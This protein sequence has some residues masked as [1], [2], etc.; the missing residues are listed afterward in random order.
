MM[1]LGR[2]SVVSDHAHWLAC[3][4]LMPSEARVVRPL[5]RFLYCYRADA[6]PAPL[7]ELCTAVNLANRF[8]M[9]EA[10]DAGML[11]LQ[12]KCR[13]READ[14]MELLEHLDEDVTESAVELGQLA[15]GKLLSTYNPLERLA[16]RILDDL[17]MPKL[18]HQL[19][20]TAATLPATAILTL[21]SN[22]ELRSSSEDAVWGVARWWVSQHYQPPAANVPCPGVVEQVLASLRWPH[23]S[24]YLVAA[25]IK[26]DPFV[27]ASEQLK[28]LLTWREKMIDGDEWE[29]GDELITH[30]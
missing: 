30:R 23:L 24:R 22:G 26:T 16:A 19:S 5:L 25:V 2:P 9:R 7:Q 6:L 1:S 10:V 20:T 8:S 15:Y 3:M 21:L 29:V 4:V 11:L 18:D 17:W 14:P 27:Q 12:H 13:A 28:Q